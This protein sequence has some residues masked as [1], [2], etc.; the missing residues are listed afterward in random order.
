MIKMNMLTHMNK[1]VTMT[2]LELVKLINELREEGAAELRH[3]SFM[4]KVLVVL[5]EEGAQKFLGSY[6]S[7]QN[8]E[9]PCYNLPKREAHLMVMSE[10]FKVQAAVY[11]RMVELESSLAPRLPQTYLEALQALTSEVAAKEEALKQLEVDH[12]KAEVYD[13]FCETSGKRSVMKWIKAIRNEHNF[14]ATRKQVFSWLRAEGYIYR[15]GRDNMPY[16][17]YE[18]CGL[19]YFSNNINLKGLG[20]HHGLL[21]TNEGMLA[22]TPKIIEAFG[23]QK[24]SFE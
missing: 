23:H 16:Q 22:L 7:S 2:S 19:N 24:A 11:D 10:S 8:K 4:A 15:S 1:E 14:V 13:Q 6:L 3:T 5:G 17:Q 18:A 12:P 21:I 9:L 20:T